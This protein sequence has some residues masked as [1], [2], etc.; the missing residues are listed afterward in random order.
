MLYDEFRAMNSDIVL[1]ASGK[2]HAA[3]DN[4]FY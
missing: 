4:G 1:A 3:I 2:D